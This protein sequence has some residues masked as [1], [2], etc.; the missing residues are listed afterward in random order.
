[1]DVRKATNKILEMIDECVLDPKDVV[2]MCLKRMSEDEVE[3][4]LDANGIEFDYEEEEYEKPEELDPWH[5]LV[6][7][8]NEEAWRLY[9]SCPT[10]E[11]AQQMEATL[12]KCSKVVIYTQIFYSPETP[13]YKSISVEE[14]I[15]IERRMR[16]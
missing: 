2:M 6:R 15:E 8:S 14:I 11:Y 16:R 1:M 12:V 13:N 4:M 3:E 7:Y 5:V 9:A 10:E